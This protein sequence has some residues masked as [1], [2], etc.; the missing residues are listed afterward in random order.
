MTRTARSAYPSA[1]NKDRSESKNG[2]DKR[3]PKNGAGP[4]NW[5]SLEDELELESAAYDDEEVELDDSSAGVSVNKH[6]ESAVPR[7]A[8]ERSLSAEEFQQ[9]IEI[10]KR[11]LKSSDVDLGSIARTAP[12]VSTSPKQPVAIVSDA[13]TTKSA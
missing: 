9:G 13:D 1:L 7:P 11:A 3:I 5:G 2:L 8:T 4:H 10:R 12:V 6:A